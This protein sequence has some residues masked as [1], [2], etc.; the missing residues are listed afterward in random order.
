MTYRDDKLNGVST[1][2][3]LIK[4]I[5]F[6]RTFSTVRFSKEQHAVAPVRR[7]SHNNS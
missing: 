6:S 7:H 4:V 3:N 2:T 1:V 5:L